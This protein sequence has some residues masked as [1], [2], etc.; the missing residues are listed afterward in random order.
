MHVTAVQPSQVTASKA[1]PSI[2]DSLIDLL[3]SL[4]VSGSDR[5]DTSNQKPSAEA[6]T[7]SEKKQQKVLLPA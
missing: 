6:D 3:S 7:K 2:D 4:R 1:S 5:E